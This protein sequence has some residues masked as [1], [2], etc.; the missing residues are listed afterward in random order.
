MTVLKSLVTTNC[1]RASVSHHH[2]RAEVER[3]LTTVN[4][5]AGT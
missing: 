3:V 1:E 5:L 4:R 2:S